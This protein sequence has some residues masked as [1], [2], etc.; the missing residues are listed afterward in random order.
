MGLF[1]N[2]II[3]KDGQLSYADILTFNILDFKGIKIDYM[4]KR[5]DESEIGEIY[6]TF[7]RITSIAK[8]INISNFDDTGIIFCTDINENYLRLRYTSTST[9]IIPIFKYNIT[10]FG[11]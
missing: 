3:L 2:E 5:G 9:N 7:D 1:A 4:I 10:L 8:I 11:L 6:L